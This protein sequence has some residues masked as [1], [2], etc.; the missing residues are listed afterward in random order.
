[1][2]EAVIR[3]GLVDKLLGFRVSGAGLSGYQKDAGVSQRAPEQPRIPLPAFDDVDRLVHG[4]LGH[5]VGADEPDL[6]GV[7]GSRIFW[8]L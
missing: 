5:A 8:D 7:C 6:Y 2:Y 3:P 1:M 4:A